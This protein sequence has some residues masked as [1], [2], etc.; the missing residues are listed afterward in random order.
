MNDE[1]ASRRQS[2]LLGRFRSGEGTDGERL[3]LLQEAAELGS[4]EAMCILGAL[5]QTG[6]GGT[7]RSLKKAA[8]LFNDALRLGYAQANARL[9]LLYETCYDDLP[10]AREHYRRGVEAGDPLSM[11]NLGRMD[12]FGKGAP[13][14]LPE[15]FRLSLAAARKG[16]HQG[17]YLAGWM[18]HL[19][20]GT[21]KDDQQAL[22]WFSRC[23][24]DY[25]DAMR[26][27][28]ILRME[29][30]TPY[31][32]MYKGIAAVKCAAAKGDPEALRM[33]ADIR[34][35]VDIH[36]LPDDYFEPPRIDA[37]EGDGSAREEPRRK[38]G[39]LDRVLRK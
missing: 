20:S 34:L 13:A 30:G 36:G 37:Y 31:R 35:D 17:M 24:R 28:G 21:A 29:E 32:D 4:P 16:E 22:Y 39:F 1:E 26:M 3:S 2:E 27:V 12:Y 18:L 10:K 7:E 14:D 15:A 38:R 9:G 23:C 19:G 11:A 8:E 6:S 33:I 5:H 25:P